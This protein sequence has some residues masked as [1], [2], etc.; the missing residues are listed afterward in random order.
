MATAIETPEALETDPVLAIVPDRIDR[1]GRYAYAA[2]RWY[3]KHYF[4][5]AENERLKSKLADLQE[6]LEIAEAPKL[7]ECPDD[8]L[9]W[10]FRLTGEQIQAV[11]DAAM[12]GQAKGDDSD[13]DRLA[14]YCIASHRRDR[15]DRSTCDAASKLKH[16]GLEYLATDMDW[17][18]AMKQYSG[19]PS[20]LIQFV[21]ALAGE[22]DYDSVQ[23]LVNQF[24]AQPEASFSD[25][26]I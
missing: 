13:A 9:E 21:E 17:V 19:Y 3:Q 6:R 16:A 5:Q 7:D 11:E 14:N 22:S 18:Q 26:R 10:T 8:R 1:S 23:V 24:Y 12:G 4:A 15:H 25:E 2:G 20:E